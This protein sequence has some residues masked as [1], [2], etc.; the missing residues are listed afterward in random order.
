MT[1]GHSF[2][3]ASA[4]PSSRQSMRR[5]NSASNPTMIR[6]TTIRNALARTHERVMQTSRLR[7]FEEDEPLR[8]A[9]FPVLHPLRRAIAIPEV[10]C[11]GH[12]GPRESRT[13][14]NAQCG[15]DVHSGG[16]ADREALFL[17]EAFDHREGLGVRNFLGVV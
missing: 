12:D 3:L 13:W 1:S 5:M 9:C 7:R 10:C 14:R 8:L 16:T 15:D 6:K 2:A 17:D 4:A 11:D